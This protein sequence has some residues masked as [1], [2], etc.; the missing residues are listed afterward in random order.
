MSFRVRFN[1]L[2]PLKSNVKLSIFC[3]AYDQFYCVLL[4][5]MNTYQNAIWNIYQ[6]NHGKEAEV[7]YIELNMA[8]II[9]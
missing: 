5:I 1:N 2:H 6:I 9:E 8:F 4:K 7:E 3:V